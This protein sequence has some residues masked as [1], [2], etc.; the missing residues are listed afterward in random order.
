MQ[1]PIC[2]MSLT[3]AKRSRRA[4]SESRSDVGMASAGI[5]VLQAVLIAD[6]AQ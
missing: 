5:R 1:A 2:R 6:L 4:S 3:G